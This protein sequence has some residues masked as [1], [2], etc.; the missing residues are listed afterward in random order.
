MFEDI[1]TSHG[2]MSEKDMLLTL[3]AEGRQA[4]AEQASQFH[5]LNTKI[6]KIMG[7]FEDF[8]AALDKVDAGVQGV[9]AELAAIAGAPQGGLTADQEASL[10]ARIQGQADKLTA[11]EV[12]PA[13]AAP[14][15]PVA[16]A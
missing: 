5:F 8:S 12:P 1:F 13:P 2:H 14:A 15:A 9:A 3:I 11:L 4:R 6:N 16:G 7:Q 10:L